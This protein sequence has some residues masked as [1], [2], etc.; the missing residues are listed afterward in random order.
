MGI[1]PNKDQI[2][3]IDNL[4]QVD[5]SYFQPNLSYEVTCSLEQVNKK[6]K[7]FV[8]KAFNTIMIDP[9]TFSVSP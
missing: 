1:K 9:V 7:G 4:I 6:T 3:Q 8:M 2:K 5:Y